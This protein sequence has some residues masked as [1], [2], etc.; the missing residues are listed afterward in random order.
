MASMLSSSQ[1][2]VRLSHP[3]LPV[4]AGMHFEHVM[5]DDMFSCRASPQGR[6]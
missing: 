1:Y 3:A 2:V 4:C 5:I 6:A